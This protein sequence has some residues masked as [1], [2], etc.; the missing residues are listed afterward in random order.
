[1]TTPPD[2][3]D[4]PN[5]KE[6]GVN[7]HLGV[8]TGRIENLAKETERARSAAEGAQIHASSLPG[9]VAKLIGPRLSNM[10]GRIA[11]LEGWRTW[12][13]GSAATFAFIIVLVEVW[14]ELR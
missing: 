4:P 5:S 10:E 9:E 3:L 7:Y 14:R 12:L 8:I 1:M 6:P 11:K 13:T 2:L